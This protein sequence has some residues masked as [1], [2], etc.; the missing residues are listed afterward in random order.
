MKLTGKTQYRAGWFGQ[1]I[2]QVEYSYGCLP[3]GARPRAD[4]SNI[5]T[6]Y[7]WRDATVAD[8][9]ARA[10]PHVPQSEENAA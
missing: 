2:L 8:V 10:I 1:I 3:A 6:R 5:V 9:F 4:G 7:E